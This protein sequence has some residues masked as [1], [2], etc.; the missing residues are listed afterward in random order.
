M[1]Q[2]LADGV[3][4][5][6]VGLWLL[7]PEHLRLGTWDLLCGWAQ[8]APQHVA[9]RLGL[10]ILH[11]AALC[12]AGV[13]RQRCLRHRGFELANG[14]PFVATDQA[15]HELLNAH[16]MAQAEALQVAL[17]RIRHGL[18]HYPGTLVAVDPHHM[19]SHTQ[20]RTRMR[21]PSAASAPAKTLQTFFCLDA[22]SHEPLCC[23]LGTS[24]PTVAQA[25][26]HLLDLAAAI[27][28][29]GP[30]RPLAVADCEH[31]TVDLVEQV[32]RQDRFDLLVP[33][34]QQPY[35]QQRL[36]AIPPE[37]FVRRWAGMA[38]AKAPYH[39]AHRADMPLSLFAQRC[40][41]RP[42]D[43]RF[44][45]FLSTA[46]ADEVQALTADYPKRWHIEEF[47]N[48]HQ[49][50]GWKRA[51]TH[52]L[53]I[54]YG[55]MT[56]ALLAEAAIS[57]LRRRLPPSLA[58]RDAPH[59]ATEIL[60]GLDGGI[61]VHEDTIVVTYYNAERLGPVAEELQ[62]L[63]ARLQREGVDPRVP[64]LYDLKLDFRLR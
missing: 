3:S 48:L 7:I 63:P 44:K 8:Q 9:P 17:G 10:Q 47:F 13:R 51:G 40:G 21:K 20:R 2:Q 12:T 28:P 55:Q 16:T 30:R 52:N 57:Q 41:E 23:T 32:R 46:D 22:D 53:H 11:E 6:L 54:R 64:W 26:P 29:E 1:R 18:G 45:G 39:F 43:Y 56:L 42:P 34:P 33:M 38:T 60:A 27:L 62:G 59:F 25:T 49:S 4:G 24:G 15:I 31:F 61:K 19:V 14:L 35:V 58:D 36:R 5:N 37:Q 50:L